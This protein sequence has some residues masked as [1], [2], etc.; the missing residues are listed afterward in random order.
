M[1]DLEPLGRHATLQRRHLAARDE[2]IRLLR[3]D[4]ASW[5]ELAS[6]A[7]LSRTAVKQIATRPLQLKTEVVS[8]GYQGL[9]LDRFLDRLGRLRVEFV[10]DVRLTPLSRKRG[11][12]KRGLAE[13]LESRG[14]KYE[15]FRDLGN[16][17]ENRDAFRSGSPAGR[18]A[19][20]AVLDG[21]GAELERLAETVA[22]ARV[23]LLCFEKEHSTCHRS[24]IIE[25]LQA[26][27]PDLSV[28]L[29]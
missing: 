15:P 22:A 1:A 3:R 4:G 12:S 2:S 21:H 5:G 23:A 6:A 19:Y 9:D 20:T 7:G 14:V 11:F 8:I 16:P 28:R 25:R 17:R 27:H 18:A 29:A 26:Q 13:A 10:A 24:L